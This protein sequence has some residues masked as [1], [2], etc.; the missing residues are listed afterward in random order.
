MTASA[1]V[2]GGPAARVERAYPT[3]DGLR[4]LAATAVV[5]T[6]TGFATGHY[7]SDAFGGLLA[8]LE[9][10]VPVF[11]RPVRVPAHPAVRTGRGAR[12]RRPTHPR[13]SLAPRAAHPAGLLAGRRGG[14]AAP[15]RQ[16]RGESGHLAAAPHADPDVHARLVR[17]RAQPHVEPLHRG[18][19]LPGAAGGRRRTGPARPGAAGPA[20]GCPRGAGRGS[21]RRPRVD[22]LVRRGRSDP[23]AVPPLAPGLRRLVRDRDGAGR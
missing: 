18:H 6:H 12:H 3:L 5:I 15:P 1:L 14:A 19:L 17:R 23:A 16:R 8:R 13:L 20:P 2:D 4:L 7:T 21:P 9:I 10:G 22:G 11:L